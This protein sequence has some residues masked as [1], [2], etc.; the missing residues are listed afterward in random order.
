MGKFKK[1]RRRACVAYY[2]WRQPYRAGSHRPYPAT[3]P[4]SQSWVAVARIRVCGREYFLHAQ[5]ASNLEARP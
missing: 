1:F 5:E 3:I 2:D 4:I